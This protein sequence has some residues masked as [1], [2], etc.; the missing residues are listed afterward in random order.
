MSKRGPKPKANVKTAWSSE[1]AYCVGLLTAD[2]CLLND[3]RHIDLTSVDKEQIV[4]FRKL[5]G[6][7]HLKIGRKGSGSISDKKY[8]RL[9]IGDVMFYQWLEKQGLHSNKSKTLTSVTVPKKYFA[10][11]IRGLFDGDGSVY[12]FW[13]KRWKSS[14]VYWI[15]ITSASDNFLLWLQNEVE[16]VLGIQGCINKRN[17]ASELRFAKNATKK[18]YRHMYHSSNAPK[19]ERKFAKLSKILSI[20]NT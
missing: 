1:L 15:T 3:G 6:L 7:E 5:L 10:D 17:R 8:Y 9:Q 14:F 4:R 13:D 18:L 11:F 12:S 16:N 2:G 20:E 19:L